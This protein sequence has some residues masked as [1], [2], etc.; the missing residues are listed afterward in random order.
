MRTYGFSA[1][2]LLELYRLH[3][4]DH[5]FI[6]PF[7]HQLLDWTAAGLSPKDEILSV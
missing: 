3:S 1:E 6:T 5:F 7:W 2:R 4:T